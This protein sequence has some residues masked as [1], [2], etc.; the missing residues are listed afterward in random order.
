M[1]LSAGRWTTSTEPIDLRKLYLP[2][3]EEVQAYFAY[4]FYDP[5]R[6]IDAVG[7]KTACAYAVDEVEHMHIREVETEAGLVNQQCSEDELGHALI[8]LVEL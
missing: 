8:T 1:Y 3:T 6:F 7:E 4:G 5:E 2:H